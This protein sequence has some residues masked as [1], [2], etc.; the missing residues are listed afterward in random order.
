MNRGVTTRSQ[1]KRDT[2]EEKNTPEM[3]D[4]QSANSNHA[5]NMCSVLRSIRKELHDF[6]TEH[7][8]DLH[9]L[10]EELKEDMKN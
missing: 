3:D 4:D 6:R 1:T 2:Q 5:E 8:A 7:K 9:T 10:K